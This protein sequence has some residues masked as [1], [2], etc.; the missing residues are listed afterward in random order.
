MYLDEPVSP[1]RILPRLSLRKSDLPDISYWEVGDSYYVVAKLEMVGKHEDGEGNK[2]EIEGNF[3][4][5]SIRAVGN[6]PID[7]KSLEKKDFEKT[8]AKVKSGKA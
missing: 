6:E 4:V 8:V 5:Q 2:K 1:E 3:K 7:V